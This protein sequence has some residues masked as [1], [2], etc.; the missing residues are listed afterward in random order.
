MDF[1]VE[2]CCGKSVNQAG[3]PY[4]HA[5]THGGHYLKRRGFT[6]QEPIMKAEVEFKPEVGYRTKVQVRYPGECVPLPTIT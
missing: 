2:L 5:A 6:P 1:F 3:V 4:F